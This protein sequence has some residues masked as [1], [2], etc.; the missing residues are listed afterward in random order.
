MT[1]SSWATRGA[2]VAAVLAVPVRAHAGEIGPTSRDTLTIGV[3]I[4]P[5]VALKAVPFSSRPNFVR[6]GANLCLTTSG[7]P[8]Y[9]VELMLPG[10]DSL[11]SA[12]AQERL[13]P[14]AQQVCGQSNANTK[15]H[16]FPEVFGG[17]GEQIS[18]LIV[19]D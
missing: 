5:S 15:R 9:H 2:I 8:H 19:P 10:S 11:I 3:V 4:P 17:S 13:D 7:L 12:T 18:V 14:I 1:R 16:Y 6:S